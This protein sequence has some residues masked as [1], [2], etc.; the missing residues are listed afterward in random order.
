MDLY[1]YQAKDLFAGHGVPVLAGAVALSPEEARA[2]AEKIG[3][4]V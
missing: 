4:Q 3:G 2:Q 1:E